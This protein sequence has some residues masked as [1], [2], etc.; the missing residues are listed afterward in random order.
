MTEGLFE[1]VYNPDVLS[2]LANLSND[3]VF[4]PP[5]IANQMLDMLPQE[6]FEN[7]DTKFLDP[8]CK[9]G[10]FLREI[11][12]RL[13]KGLE[14][15]IPD[16]QER[17][18]HIYQKQLYGIAITELTSLMSRRSTYCSKS[19]NTDFS[20]SKFH[21]N[22]PEGNIRFRRIQHTWQ[23]G[24]CAFCGASQ[25]EYDR[26]DELE[27]HAYEWIHTMQPEDIFKMRFDVIISNPPYQIST[28]GSLDMQATPLY[29]KFV[30]VSKQLKP[31]YI[32]MIIPSRW[33]NG[34]FA[35][36]KFREEMLDDKS[37]R[38]L[39]DFLDAQECFSGI[40]LTGGVCYFLW[41][42]DHTGKC[43]IY[44]H[45]A[46]DKV[47]ESE[48]F[49]R[50][51]GCN[52][53]IRY[54]QAISILN[55]VRAF[56]EESFSNIVSQRDP[57]GLNY[58]EGHTERMFK[59]SRFEYFE[60]A[61]K[62]YYFGWQSKGIGYVEPSK[63]TTRKDVVGKYKVMISKA[64]GAASKQAPYAVIS[65]PFIARPNECCNMTYLS[66]GQF[67]TEEEARNCQIY[68]TTKFFRFLVS[69]LKNTQNALRKVYEFVPLQNFAK[70]W[71]DEELYRKYQLTEEEIAYVE[72]MIRPMELDGGN[73]DG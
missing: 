30:Q 18:D 11:A 23:K 64:N 73:D 37:I 10:V 38:V 14:P 69:L 58:F 66:V 6:L 21:D 20:I 9:S 29:D 40:N 62:V 50:E 72:D 2:C 48:R 25:E 49:L 43:K 33:M 71:S 56:G 15:Q 28:G 67:N 12:K 61:V 47:V 27:T 44:T 53:Y 70:S 51:D 68:I 32:T 36:D 60:G 13:L 3:E 45:E 5:E 19:P 65:Q 57:F 26:S 46:S 22:N 4:T 55:K 17:I 24:R 63:I 16:L 52:T 42:R 1:K 7:P 8:A 54:S 34:G 41:D 35:L 31:R 59:P 39:H